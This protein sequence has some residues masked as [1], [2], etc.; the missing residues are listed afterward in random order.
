MSPL[1][2]ADLIRH[3]MVILCVY[4]KYLN[5]LKYM[6]MLLDSNKDVYVHEGLNTESI[7]L[8]AF[9]FHHWGVELLL[10]RITQF[11]PWPN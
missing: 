8:R 10:L 5:K 1:L 11:F 6:L 3:F 4:C 2:Y 7:N 9:C